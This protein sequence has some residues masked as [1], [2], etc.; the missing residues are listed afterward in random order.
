MVVFEGVKDMAREP[1]RID[2]T[3]VP[4]LLRIAEEV[5]ASQEPR[6][7]RRDNEDVAILMPARRA[8][9]PTRGRPLIH[10][11][12]LWKLLGSAASTEVTDASKKHEYLAEALAPQPARR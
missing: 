8:R 7:L 12:P 2:I 11:D 10:D 4:E 9:K 6:V 3:N 5:R 1:K